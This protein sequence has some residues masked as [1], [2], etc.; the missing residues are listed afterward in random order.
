MVAEH[1]YW[2]RA[3]RDRRSRRRVLVQF[4]AGLASVSSLGLL[5]CGRRQS[6]KGSAASGAGSVTPKPGGTFST[7]NP[8][9]IQSLDP[10][11][12]QSISSMLAVDGVTS[13]VYRFKTGPDPQTYSN[14]EPI[15]DLAMTAESPDAVTWT[16]KIRRDANFQNLAPVNGHAVEAED[17]KA[18]IVRAFKVTANAFLSNLSAVDPNQIQTP[19]ADTIVFK[20]KSPFTAFTSVLANAGTEIL[21]REALAGAYDPREHLI[22]SGPFMFDSYTPDVGWTLKKNPQWFQPNHPYVD[23]VHASIVPDTAQQLAQFAAGHLDELF[24]SPLD[25]STAMQSNPKAQLFKGTSGGSYLLNGHSDH[26]S[27]PYAD[28]NVRRALS[29]A[30]DRNA[31]GKAVFNNEYVNNGVVPAGSGNWALAPDQFGDASQYYQYN[32]D[33]AKQLVQ[34]TPA[35]KKLNQLLYPASYYGRQFDTMCQTVGSML[36][37]AGFEPQLV[38]IDY[39]K[40]YLNNGKGTIYGGFPDNALMLSTMTVHGDSVG[41]LQMF[42]GSTGGRVKQLNDPQL[43]VMLSKTQGIIDANERLKAVQDIQRYI[44]SKMYIV[45]LPV[46]YIF[47]LVQPSVRN[48]YYGGAGTE[49]GTGTW[50]WLW[51][52]R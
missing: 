52:S 28:L 31:I 34:Q 7:Y 6:G 13:Y 23:S 12:G 42:Y 15:G 9:N 36:N 48:Y 43:D 24:P 21:P 37:A 44:A 39:Q 45:P 49:T 51:L 26:P 14:Y 25:L 20:L 3:D 18:T 40:D 50:P 8:A 10:Q 33:A 38:P 19:A 1:G 35:A 2:S 11:S 29:M 16:V 32:L 41:T 27:S 30:I 5:A 47:S 22:G 17:I 4:A 46:S